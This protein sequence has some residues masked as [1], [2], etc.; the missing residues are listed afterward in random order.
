MVTSKEQDPEPLPLSSGLAWRGKETPTHSNFEPLLSHSHGRSSCQSDYRRQDIHWTLSHREGRGARDGG[1]CALKDG[2]SQA[3][4]SACSV[5]KRT[6]NFTASPSGRS[7]T[8]LLH[9]LIQYLSS[10]WCLE[11]SPCI[12]GLAE[13]FLLGPELSLQY[14][15]LAIS[16]ERFLTSPRKRPPCYFCI[17]SPTNAKHYQLLICSSVSP[18]C[19][20]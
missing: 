19:T 5:S 2:T 15:T 1:S 10:I 20:L 16:T 14:D 12:S 18:A 4:L 17:K 3:S 13:T 7:S 8:S 6:F 11:N 9:L